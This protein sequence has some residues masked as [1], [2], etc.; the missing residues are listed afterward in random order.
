[1]QHALICMVHD[2]IL[3]CLNR[4]EAFEL[5]VLFAYES[6]FHLPLLELFIEEKIRL[7]ACG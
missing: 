5:D 2:R 3:I 1:M 4:L 6:V 7:E